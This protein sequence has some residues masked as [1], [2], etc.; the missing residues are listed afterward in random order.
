MKDTYA[1]MVHVS[2]RVGRAHE[3]MDELRARHMAWR[4]QHGKVGNPFEEEERKEAARR[5]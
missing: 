5:K 2:A 1:Y 3:R 4:A